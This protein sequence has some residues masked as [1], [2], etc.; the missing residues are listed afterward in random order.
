MKRSNLLKVAAALGVAAGLAAPASAQVSTGLQ[1]AAFGGA[2]TSGTYTPA[3][4]GFSALSTVGGTTTTNTYTA[5]GEQ[6]GN[7]QVTKTTGAGGKVGTFTASLSEGDQQRFA[8]GTS[9]NLGVSAA[10]SSTSDYQANSSANFGFGSTTLRQSIGTSGISQDSNQTEK[11]KASYVETTASSAA[12][13]SATTSVGSSAEKYYEK[14]AATATNTNG[15]SSNSGYGWWGSI[16]NTGSTTK[17]WSQ[18]SSDEKSA[19]TSAYNSAYT[20]AYNS[21]YSSA[22]TTAASDY[23]TSASAKEAATGVI[24]GSFVS[25]SSQT[26]ATAPNSENANNQVTVK[27]IGNAANV[28]ATGNSY[29]TSTVTSRAGTPV[30]GSSGTGSGSAG[31]NVSSTASADAAATK[32]S[33]VFIQSY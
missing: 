15:T 20:S 22:A 12:A 17:T 6:V 28:N 26:A 32:F 8:V 11:A 27:G 4:T 29:F 18:L 33:S 21:A 1:Q 24:S 23:A 19:V 25:S 13:S 16:S 9:T 3:S 7:T 10:S 31:A 14:A 2:V 5:A 30:A